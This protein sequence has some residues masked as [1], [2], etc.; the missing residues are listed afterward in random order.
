MGYFNR[1]ESRSSWTDPRPA[2]CHVLYL[3]MKMIRILCQHAGVNVV[4]GKSGG[5]GGGLFEP[6]S[7]PLQSGRGDPSSKRAKVKGRDDPG[8]DGLNQPGNGSGRG[9]WPKEDL[10]SGGNNGGAIDLTDDG[11]DIDERGGFGGGSPDAD[12]I[13]GKKKKKKKKDKGLK[14]GYAEGMGGM[15]GMAHSQSEPAGA[16]GS[17]GVG[18]FGRPQP[19]SSAVDDVRSALGLSHQSVPQPFAFGGM[20][21]DGLSNVGRARVK[22]GIRLQPIAG[23][24]PGVAAGEDSSMGQSASVPALRQPIQLNPL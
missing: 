24:N 12:E 21:P 22:A 20:E 15:G 9:N 3:K 8:R 13:Y 16:M 11:V 5:A 17:Q 4:D 18:A 7:S 10:F 23:P 2:K 1:G 6:L 19:P 14:D